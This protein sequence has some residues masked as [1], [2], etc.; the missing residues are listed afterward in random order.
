MFF[1]AMRGKNC[2]KELFVCVCVCVCSDVRFW[3]E[4]PLG[5]MVVVLGNVSCS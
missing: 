4:I 2:E 3:N 5:L 1:L